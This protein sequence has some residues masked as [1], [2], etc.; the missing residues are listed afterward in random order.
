VV[1][2]PQRVTESHLLAEPRK[3]TMSTSAPERTYFESPPPPTSPQDR[4]VR[5]P[6][7]AILVFAVIASGLVTGVL[8]ATGVAGSSTKTVVAQSA[9]GSAGTGPGAPLNA[10][11]L[12]QGAAPGVVAIE[13][14]APSSG[15]NGFPYTPP[16][17]SIDTGTGIVIDTKG[18]ILTASHVWPARRRSR[19][20]S[21][22]AR[23]APQA[24]SAPT[25]QTTPRCCT[26]V[27]PA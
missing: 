20:S 21:S 14:T 17:Q 5:R 9:Q 24:S 19:S 10:S 4:P 6:V 8:Y 15:S 18:D 3:V 2:V 27:R 11:A 25:P 16:G 13:A 12:Y 7:A 22:T 1:S 26:S 23:F